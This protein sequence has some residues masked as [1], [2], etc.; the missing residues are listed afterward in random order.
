[1]ITY[2]LLIFV[3]NLIVTETLE[4]LANI[5]I[6]FVLTKLS[7]SDRCEE[8]SFNIKVRRTVVGT[9]NTNSAVMLLWTTDVTA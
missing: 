2:L 4:D 3:Q 5:R 8:I 9:L 1:M 7:S 6:S